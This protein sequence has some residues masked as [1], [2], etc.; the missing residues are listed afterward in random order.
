M[1]LLGEDSYYYNAFTGSQTALTG[2]GLTICAGGGGLCESNREGLHHRGKG[3]AFCRQ[4]KAD[5]SQ[6]LEQRT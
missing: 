2:I 4:N 5:S 3:L 1:E 6:W